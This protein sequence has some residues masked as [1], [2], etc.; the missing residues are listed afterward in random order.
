MDPPRHV[1]IV[2]SNCLG[3]DADF[4]TWYDSI[5]VPD[6]LRL[7]GFVRARR[8]RIQPG[9]AQNDAAPHEFVTLFEIEGD[10]AAALA[11]L[12]EAAPAMDL[13]DGLLDLEH[14]RGWLLTPVSES[15]A[16]PSA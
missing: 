2:M 14:V 9:P 3:D 6:V 7:P 10:P 12:H 5:H 13:A 15:P 1:L 11:A 8:Y 16:T 4:N